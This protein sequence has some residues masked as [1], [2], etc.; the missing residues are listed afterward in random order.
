MEGRIINFRRGIKTTYERQM[1]V[2]VKG[3]DNKEKAS[4][5]VGK[6]AVWT[7]PGKGKKQIVGVVSTV[8]GGKGALRVVF[9][10]GMPG[11]A[12][13]TKVKIE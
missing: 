10:R 12:V 7:S 4:S 8:H 3:I 1:I 9:E 13:G 6:K 5:L 11:Q 2:E